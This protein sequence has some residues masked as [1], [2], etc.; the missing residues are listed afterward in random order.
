MRCPRA[1]CAGTASPTCLPSDV[2]RC[3]AA[4]AVVGRILASKMSHAEVRR[5]LGGYVGAGTLTDDVLAD[6]H[7]PR[8][9]CGA[10][11]EPAGGGEA[12]AARASCGK[13]AAAESSC[14]GGSAAEEVEPGDAEAGERC[15]RACACRQW[16][17][18]ERC[19]IGAASVVQGTRKQNQH[20]LLRS[21]WGWL[22]VSQRAL[23]DAQPPSH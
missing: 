19:A 15:A 3:A 13:G 17:S 9:A 2:A 4:Y 21:L 8:A 1:R 12:T 16:Q 18:V 5:L 6:A 14:G 7:A 23:E 10:P 22:P 11:R 20:A